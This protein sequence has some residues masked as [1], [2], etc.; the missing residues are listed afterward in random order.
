MRIG[1]VTLNWYSNYGNL[2]QKY[3]LHQ[4]LKLFAEEV[5]VLWRGYY[6]LYP[7]SGNATFYQIVRPHVSNDREK[8]YTLREAIRQSKFKDF[9][10]LHINT[11]FDFPYLEDIADE[12]DFFVVGSDNIWDPNKPSA[13]YFLDFVPREKKITYA[14]SVRPFTKTPTAEIKELF[15]KGISGFAHLSIREEMTSK[16]VEE[17]AGIK[18]LAVLDPIFLLT[19]DD[20][21]KVA[22]KPT[23]LKEK[24]R[25]GYV[26]TYYLRRLPPPEVKTLADELDLPIINLLDLENYDHFTVGPAE[27]VW[28]FK[29]A[30]LILGNSFH[31]IAFA[32]LFKRPFINRAFK[33]D[34]HGLSL[35]HRLLNVLKIFGLEERRT[36]GEKVFSAEEAL[37]I[38]FSRRDE[39]LP[40]ERAK[41]F[42]FLGEAL[43]ID[44]LE[45]FLRGDS[46]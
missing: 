42:K 22:Q 18:P 20:W 5:E 34:K 26:L 30:S 32:I 17:V 27:F 36:F 23:W 1:Q 37:T 38:D 19:T 11:R 16:A 8:L 15:R 31:A 29:N 39:V 4:T 21:D 41:A 25:R 44:P 40:R 24:Y 43:G 6:G 14:V 28:L 7:E 13:E 12:Y 45:I 3:A 46:R 9:E 10:N 33:D 35:S 2:L